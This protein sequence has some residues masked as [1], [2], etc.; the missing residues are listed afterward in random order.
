MSKNEKTPK[1]ANDAERPAYYK[2]C[3]IV[4][5]VT[6]IGGIILCALITIYPI[7]TLVCVAYGIWVYVKIREYNK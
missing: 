5:V 2:R 7:L 6:R 4:D 1:F 3:T